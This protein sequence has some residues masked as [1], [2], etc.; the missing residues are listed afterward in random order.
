MKC[1]LAVALA[2]LLVAVPAASAQTPPPTMVR[3][4]TADPPGAYSA[5]VVQRS[6]GCTSQPA[7]DSSVPFS[8]PTYLFALCQP[9]LRLSF[10]SPQASVQVMVRALLHPAAEVVARANSATG[11]VL[12]EVTVADP[13]AWRPVSLSSPDGAPSIASID[14]RA[15]GANLGVDDLALSA[16][17]QPDT[18]VTDAP[19][20]RTEARGAS[21]A[22]GANRP[23][24]REWRC[25]LD[26][27]PATPCTSPKAYVDL[28]PG[29]H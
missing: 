13:A 1:I 3:F 19:Q 29:P 10:P 24:V 21:F 20:A 14:L 18:S 26:G 25:S 5:T 2:G 22:F 6:P 4:E 8:A 12:R 9:T 23:D 11:A 27:A 16:S 28:A 17:P 7:F 15:E